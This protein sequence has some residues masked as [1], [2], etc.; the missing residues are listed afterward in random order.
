ML[1]TRADSVAKMP[2]DFGRQQWDE[3]LQQQRRSDRI[4]QERARQ[5]GSIEIAQ[6]LFGADAVDRQRARRVD[7]ESERA[8]GSE[9]AGAFR[10]RVLVREV[11]V[12]IGMAAQS[13]H[14]RRTPAFVAAPSRKRRRWRLWPPGRWPCSRRADCSSTPSTGSRPMLPARRPADAGPALSAHREPNDCSTC[15]ASALPLSQA[16]STLPPLSQSPHR[17]RP[18]SGSQAQPA[19]SGG[20]VSA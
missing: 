16:P 11:E 10:N 20:S 19:S 6:P 9:D 14:A 12:R 1:P 17:P 18:R 5:P 8:A 15:C 3:V 2:R 7:D 13:D 4:D